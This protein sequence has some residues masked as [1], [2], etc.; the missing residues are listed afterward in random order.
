M[1]EEAPSPLSERGSVAATPVLQKAN[2]RQRRNSTKRSL[3][4][5][6]LRPSLAEGSV[7]SRASTRSGRRSYVQPAGILQLKAVLEELPKT[8]SFVRRKAEAAVDKKRDHQ[9][10]EVL[11]EILKTE[12]NYLADLQFIH[13]EFVTPLQA[14]LSHQM[15]ADIF[16]NLT[17]L[18]QLHGRLGAD[19]EPARRAVK[20]GRGTEQLAAAIA[21]AFTPFIPLLMLYATYCGKF[22]DAPAKVHE[23]VR[24]SKKAAATIA[25][26]PAEFNTALEALLFR[27]VQRMC[28]Y[29]LLFRQALKHLPAESE[30]REDFEASSQAIGE[31][32]A[33]VN[34]NVREQ[35]A[36]ARTRHV[37]IEE[38]HSA[39]HLLVPLRRLVSEA[40]VRLQRVDGTVLAMGNL[41]HRRRVCH[42]FIFSDLLLVCRA[43]PA[44]VGGGFQ[45]VLTLPLDTIDVAMNAGG[46]EES[47]RLSEAASDSAMA[48]SEPVPE[49]TRS[50]RVQ[51]Q[52]VRATRW[53]A[54]EERKRSVVARQLSSSLS[55]DLFGDGSSGS[56]NGESSSG[57]GGE[58]ATAP[59][60]G[61]VSVRK[62]TWS[63]LLTLAQAQLEGDPTPW[64]EDDDLW[65]ARHRETLTIVHHGSGGGVYKLWAISESE[66]RSLVR[67]LTELQ[68][69]YRKDEE[70]L[71]LR[72]SEAAERERRGR[73][74]HRKIWR[75]RVPK[76][77]PNDTVQS[78]D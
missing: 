19:L 55:V 67:Q 44:A 52:W 57:V 64:K 15:H 46:D 61:F 63:N 5:R 56:L 73:L 49:A 14:Q 69:A 77:D 31:T 47:G 42:L 3:T 51:R 72:K 68:D 10:R 38:V 43:R 65:G 74:A 78:D 40:S 22:T 7:S 27:P 30:A 62:A 66:G 39:S 9:L 16:A 53:V 59:A 28:V 37:L 18:M 36:E 23:A 2:W 71:A 35:E 8:A 34:E 70:M 29:P 6:V 33:Q 45:R 54:A 11:E 20:D 13:R 21:K 12:T 4:L 25:R 24:R 60:N 48:V 26:G 58:A 50:R 1:P 75:Q 32:I 17:Q 76:H 41:L